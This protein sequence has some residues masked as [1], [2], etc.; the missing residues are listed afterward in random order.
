MCHRTGNGQK[1]VIR[2]TAT[3]ASNYYYNNN[4]TNER[5]KC[6]THDFQSLREPWRKYLPTAW[7]VTKALQEHWAS[8]EYLISCIG[9]LWRGILL[10]SCHTWGELVLLTHHNR[11]G[12]WGTS[13]H[14]LNFSRVGGVWV[15]TAAWSLAKR[16]G[17]SRVPKLT[18]VT[19][20]KEISYSCVK[21][22]SSHQLILPE[23]LLILR[24]RRKPPMELNCSWL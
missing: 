1:K 11:E 2:R 4:K 19:V 21:R 20:L 17:H 8:K 23:S 7:K 9:S 5:R 6:S 14:S 3:A 13:S 24:Q 10:P 12:A 16:E 18:E 15:T 22:T